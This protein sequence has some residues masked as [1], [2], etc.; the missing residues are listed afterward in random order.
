MAL[1][2]RAFAQDAAAPAASPA[3]DAPPLLPLP[4]HRRPTTVVATVG[5]KPITEGDLSLAAEDLQQEL[6]QVPP[7]QQ[8]AFLLSPC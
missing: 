4:P 6:Q 8:R 5:G 7:E 1:S 3:T 2:L